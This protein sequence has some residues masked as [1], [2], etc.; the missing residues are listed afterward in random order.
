MRYMADV[1][2]YVISCFMT[3]VIQSRKRICGCFRRHT[4]GGV[5]HDRKITQ[6]SEDIPRRH[7]VDPVIQ[8]GVKPR[9]IRQG[10]DTGA[11]AEKH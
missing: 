3:I 10:K 5:I 6:L 4:A 9:H 1:H 2:Y 11:A 8:A 7:C